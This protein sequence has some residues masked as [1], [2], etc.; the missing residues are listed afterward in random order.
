MGGSDALAV[1]GLS[2]WDS[3]YSVWLDK[4][5]RA[6]MTTTTSLRMRLGHLLEPIVVQLFTEETGIATRR[7]G[8]WRSR[9][10]P[11]MLANPDRDTADGGVLECKTTDAWGAKHWKGDDMPDGAEM[12]TQHYHAVRGT[13]HGWVAAL[14]GNARLEV[15]YLPRDDELIGH[16]VAIQEDFWRLVET[17]TPPPIDGSPATT[18]AIRAVADAV[19]EGAMVARVPDRAADIIVERRRLA[20]QLKDVTERYEAASNELK[21]LIGDAAFAVD[22]RGRALYSFKRFGRTNVPV[23][24]LREQ[25]PEIAAALEVVSEYRSLRIMVKDLEGMDDDG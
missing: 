2:H 15:R 22:G 14:I 8:T 10:W 17:E 3:P 4:T 7:T 24:A 1:A 16:M 25:H 13:R 18:E 6:A 21:A 5:G 9:R 23:A 12:Q 19:G 20:R 11:W